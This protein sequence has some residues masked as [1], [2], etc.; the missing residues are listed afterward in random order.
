ML[1]FCLWLLLVTPLPT[2]SAAAASEDEPRLPLAMTVLV[3]KPKPQQYDLHIHLTNISQNPIT[4]DVHDLP[5]NPPNDSKWLNAFRLDVH[6]SPLTQHTVR[7]DVGSQEVRLLPGES[8][9]DTIA[10]NPRIPSLLSDIKR[11]GIQLNWDCPPP[12][13][14]FVCD[15]HAPNNITIPKRDAGEPDHTPIDKTA[16][17]ARARTIQL[18]RIP[19]DHDVLF[20]RT[21]EA[22]MDNVQQVQALLYQVDDYIQHCQPM[23]TNSWAVS[24]FTEEKY[25]GF[26]NDTDNEPYYEQGLWQRAN[27]GQYSSQIRTLYRFPWDKKKSDTVYLSVYQ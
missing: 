22:I 26:L 27:I 13:L 17:R 11:F 21:T 3:K 9:Q 12:S 19:Q 14:K 24:F 1:V 2:S 4:V 16:C 15:A 10:L 18:I 5:W 7:W 25:A 6:N 23:W 8:I 20:L